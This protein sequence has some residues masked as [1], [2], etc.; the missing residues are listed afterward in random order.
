MWE[1][2]FGSV[3]PAA[4]AATVVASAPNQSPAITPAEI[5]AD[6]TDVQNRAVESLFAGGDFTKLFDATTP[7][8]SKST[9]DD[10]LAKQGLIDAAFVGVTN[11]RKIRRD[12][13]YLDLF[14]ENLQHRRD[15]A[16]A[17]Q[18][19]DSDEGQG[20]LALPSLG[21]DLGMGS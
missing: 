15:G 6:E 4:V 9:T 17:G 20:L 19:G 14:A 11:S 2:G 5:L 1:S 10:A 16:A 7:N 13:T 8:A 3:G 18:N 21:F 12:A